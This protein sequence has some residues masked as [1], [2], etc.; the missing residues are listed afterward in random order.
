ML[1]RGKERRGGGRERERERAQHC[2]DVYTELF[3]DGDRAT[4]YDFVQNGAVRAVL[5]STTRWWMVAKTDSVG[6]YK[7]RIASGE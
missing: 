7:G 1:E 6:I 2:M 5:R 3:R 4:K